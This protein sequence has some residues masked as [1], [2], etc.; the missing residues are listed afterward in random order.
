[1]GVL[2]VLRRKDQIAADPADG[3]EGFPP[4]LPEVQTGNH[5]RRP[6]ILGVRDRQVNRIAARRMRRSAE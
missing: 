4:F 3:T 6:A 5:D 2:P 1:M